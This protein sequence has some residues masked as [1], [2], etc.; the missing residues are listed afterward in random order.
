MLDIGMVWG[1]LMSSDT[2]ACFVLDVLVWVLYERHVLHLR[3]RVRSA[4]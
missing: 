2:R 4:I 3:V 1:V